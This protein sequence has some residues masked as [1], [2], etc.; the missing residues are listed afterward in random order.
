M[1]TIAELAE[2]IHRIAGARI[3]P[4]TNGRQQRSG[5]IIGLTLKSISDGTEKKVTVPPNAN[6]GGVS[7]S[8]DG[9]RLSFTNTK[10][11]AIELWVADTV[12]RAV[13][14]FVKP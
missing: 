14:K 1:P 5:G 12:N 2:S 11:N 13:Q 7:F 9:K 8:A 10:E 6:I 4:K 3:N